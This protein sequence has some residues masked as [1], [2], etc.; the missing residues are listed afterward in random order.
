MSEIS[1]PNASRELNLIKIL[2]LGDQAVGKTS[3]LLR[4][5]K[6]NFSEILLPTL[7]VDFKQKEVFHKGQSYYLQIWD[8]AGQERFRSV[9]RTYYKK[10]SAVILAYDCTNMQSFQNIQQWLGQMKSEVDLN[11]PVVLISTKNDLVEEVDSNLGKKLAKEMDVAFFKTS[12]K[13][14]GGVDEMFKFILEQVLIR[15]PQKE[16]NSVS[17]ANPKR[18]KKCC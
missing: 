4:Y 6:S 17:L 15:Q 12:A 14:G 9:T 16:R 10:A 13:D 11:A 5:S 1:D 3:I 2:I 7:G 18:K 8:S